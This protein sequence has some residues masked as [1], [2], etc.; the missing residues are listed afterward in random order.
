MNTDKKLPEMPKLP[1]IAETERVTGDELQGTQ[2]FSLDFLA[3]FG[4]F[5]QLSGPA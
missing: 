3:I 2:F 1:K 4:D 5:W